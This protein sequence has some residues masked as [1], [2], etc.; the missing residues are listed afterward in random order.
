MVCDESS[1]AT[2][3]TKGTSVS[4]ALLKSLTEIDRPTAVVPLFELRSAVG[5]ELAAIREYTV[6]PYRD[7]YLTKDGDRNRPRLVRVHREKL[8]ERLDP[9]AKPIAAEKFDAPQP[10]ATTAN[11][12]A[13]KSTE[14][15]KPASK[16]R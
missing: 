15:P 16:S 9:P 1:N 5:D 14:A 2:A 10:Q 12:D 6:E 7:A 13:A 8:L 11:T 4:K 3:E